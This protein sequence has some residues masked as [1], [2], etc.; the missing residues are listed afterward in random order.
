MSLFHFTFEKR[1][2]K[3]SETVLIITPPPPKIPIVTP[4]ELKKTIQWQENH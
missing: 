3:S 2:E 4:E 1:D